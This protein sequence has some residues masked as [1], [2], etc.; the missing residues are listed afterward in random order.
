[1]DTLLIG[2]IVASYLIL[3]VLGILNG[4]EVNRLRK[5]I[6]YHNLICQGTT[7]PEHI[8]GDTMCTNELKR[9]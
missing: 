2:F 6:A 3:G 4:F 9:T 5:Q 7:V 8:C 1:M